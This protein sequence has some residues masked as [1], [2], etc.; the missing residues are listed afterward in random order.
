MA[1]QIDALDED[2]IRTQIVEPAL[3]QAA[4]LL[5]SNIV[6]AVEAAA[7]ELGDRLIKE[8]SGVLNGVLNGLQGI[9]EKL[10]VDAGQLLAKQDGWEL[11]ITIPPITLH[12]SK[13]KE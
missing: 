9:T 4:T 2:R 1:L 13:P 3:N 8:I 6:P 12:L 10:V 7:S 5:Q 11:S